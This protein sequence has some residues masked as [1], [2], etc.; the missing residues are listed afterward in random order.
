MNVKSKY[1]HNTMAIF[2]VSILRPGPGAFEREISAGSSTMRILEH[3]FSE[4]CTWRKN[5]E[6]IGIILKDIVRYN[7]NELLAVSRTKYRELGH[8]FLL[9]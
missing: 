1:A 2:L 7:L 3:V 5:E 4:T 9:H 6:R 8:L